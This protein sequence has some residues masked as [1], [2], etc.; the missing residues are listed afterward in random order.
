MILLDTNILVYATV[1]GF[2]EHSRA[3]GLLEDI[4]AGDSLYCVT[5]V[6]LFEYL[7][8]VTHRRLIRPA[9][10]PIEEALQNIRNL[11]NSPQISRIDPE[12]RH[13]EIFEDICRKAAPVEGNFVHDCRI[14]AIM[15]ENGVTDI[16][17]RDSSFRRI[18]GIKVIDPFVTE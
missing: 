18:P 14:A 12:E 17:T 15:R 7:R 3:R 16:L 8:A 1:P 13:L 4:P 11:L 6:N 2:E 9:P 5:W 10:L